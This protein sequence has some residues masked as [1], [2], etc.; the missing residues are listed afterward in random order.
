M[1]TRLLDLLQ[2]PACKGRLS[3]KDFGGGVDPDEVVDGLL[4]CACGRRYPIVDTIPRMLPDAFVL[5]PEFTERH[6][7]RLGDAGATLAPPSGKFERLL[8]QTR[9]SFSYQWTTFSEMVC[10]FQD[11]F[12]NYLHPATPEMFRGRLGLDA[13]CGFGRHIYHA[14]ACG[15]E[16]VGMDFSKAIDSTRRNTRHLPNVHL[17]QGDIY[18]PP[19]AEGVFDFVYSIG[20][21]HHLPDPERGLRSLTPMLRPGGMAFIWVYS[22]TRSVTNF[23]LEIVRTVTTRLPYPI[24][25]ALSFVGAVVDQCCFVLPYQ[26]L[27]QVPG[28]GQLVDRVV[29]PRIRMYSAYP[30]AVL[31]ADWFDRLAAPIRFYY[32]EPEVERLALQ[33]G[34][35]DV[36]VTPTGAYGWRACGVR[37]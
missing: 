9:D 14:A 5:F 23:F 17:V 4:R 24:V 7:A 37:R 3:C 28:L 6:R 2:C 12:W 35:S 10:D 11:N 20:V 22:K 15:A 13:G 36:K 16:M 33:A 34:I 25:N 1:R 26:V 21:L 31:H 30:F 27:R 8:G 29:L 32:S 18:A 19:L